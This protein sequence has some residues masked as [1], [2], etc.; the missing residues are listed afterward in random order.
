MLLNAT[1]VY[2]INASF[3]TDSNSKPIYGVSVDD[4][5]KDYISIT[6]DCSYEHDNTITIL[7]LLDDYDVKATFFMT[8]DFIK[9]NIELVTEVIK[10]GHEIGNHTTRHLHFNHQSDLTIS[11]E[12]MSCHNIFK[13]LFGQDMT[14][15]RF[16]YGEYTKSSMSIVRSLNYYPIQWTADSFDWEN[17]GVEHILNNLSMQDAYRPGG[18]LLFHDNGI[19][20]PFALPAIF[21][22]IKNLGLKCVKVSE[23]IYEDN[24]YVDN[25]GIQIKY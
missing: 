12:I 15:F 17:R 11:N 4:S 18:I 21:E 20:T 1:S 16:P 8:G 9:N 5:R 25:K 6:F 13:N 7:N 2:T 23:L 3:G 14:L 10:R 22:N 19:F 24:F